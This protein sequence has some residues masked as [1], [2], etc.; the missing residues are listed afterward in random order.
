MIE[1]ETLSTQKNLTGVPQGSVLG[2]LLSL[3]YSNDLNNCIQFSKAYH[4]A[5]DTNI[6]QSNISLEV[7][8]KQMNKDLLN[9]SYWLIFRPT[10]FKID[11]SIKFKLQGMRLIPGQSVKYLGVF[12]DEHSQ[13]TKQLPN[14]KIKLNKAIG[15]LSKLRHNSN[16][17]ILKITYRSLFGSHLLY[18][19]QLWGQKN[20]TSLNQI[21]IL[22]NRALKG[23][24]LRKAITP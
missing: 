23:M 16:L 19:C 6:M 13:W 4:F 10:G 20:Q 1:N 18:G 8:A 5:D 2:S 9:L 12:L 17:D 15:I 11:P 24:T 3:I 22:R 14:V 21:Q 7:L